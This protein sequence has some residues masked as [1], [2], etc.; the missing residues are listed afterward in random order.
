MHAAPVSNHIYEI[1]KVPTLLDLI[2]IFSETQTPMSSLPRMDFLDQSL[3][4]LEW[5]VHSY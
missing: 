2:N 4:L 3:F 1:L 5:A